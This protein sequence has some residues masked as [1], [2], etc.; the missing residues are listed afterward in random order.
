MYS[1]RVTEITS[2]SGGEAKN[3]IAKLRREILLDFAK[4]TQ[5]ISDNNRHPSCRQF[6]DIRDA[7]KAVT[8]NRPAYIP[9]GLSNSGYV[10]R[11]QLSRRQRSVPRLTTGERF[12]SGTRKR[13]LPLHCRSRG[14][15]QALA[16]IFRLEIRVFGEN[17][18]LRSSASQQ[19]QHGGDRYSQMAHTR[20]TTHLCRINGDMLEILHGCPLIIVAVDPT[21]RKSVV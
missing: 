4:V 3:C 1:R 17:L 16:N 6:S 20:D 19:S 12:S 7:R 13:Q 11:L 21:D 5:L 14:E 8:M 9:I 18:K 2:G 15:A 10:I